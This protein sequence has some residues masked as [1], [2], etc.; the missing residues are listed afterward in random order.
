V[1]DTI[2]TR[3]P[4]TSLCLFSVIVSIIQFV[5][6]VDGSLG[7]R[8]DDV[9]AIEETAVEGVG[10]AERAATLD[11]VVVTS[12]VLLGDTAER[13]T[14]CEIVSNEDLENECPWYLQSLPPGTQRPWLPF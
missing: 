2:F 8:L 5:N 4:P 7:E 10:T 6:L 9:G 12:E 11:D 14:A 1:S 13:A 3:S